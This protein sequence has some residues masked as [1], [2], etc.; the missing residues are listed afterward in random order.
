MAIDSYHSL[1]AG[2]CNSAFCALS[3]L[4]RQILTGQLHA[5]YSHITTE[6]YS[7]A[8]GYSST[9]KAPLERQMYQ[10]HSLSSSAN[11]ADGLM[12]PSSRQPTRLHT[13]DKSW[14]RVKALVAKSH[15]CWRLCTMLSTWSLRKWLLP[16]YIDMGAH[17]WDYRWFSLVS[18]LAVVLRLGS[19]HPGI[20][21][22]SISSLWVAWT[23]KI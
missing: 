17:T 10:T 22:I 21:E 13:L 19:S 9:S 23:C 20:R 7:A 12:A 15:W 6:W 1:T 16:W 3:L 2:V 11:D 14:S 8:S 4:Q 18:S 5:Y